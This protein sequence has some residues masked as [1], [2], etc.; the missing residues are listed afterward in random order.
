M[1]IGV[2]ISQI[3]YQTGV[4]RYTSQLI[5]NLLKFD[6]KNQYTLFAGSIRQRDLIESFYQ[7]VKTSQTKLKL[8]WLSP[9]LA[10]ILWNR[11]HL[12]PVERFTGRLDVF[13]SSDWTQ[14]PSKA[15]KVTTVHDLT[16]IKFP[17]QHHPKI[18]KTHRRRLFWVKKQADMIIADSRSTKN[19]LV[20]TLGFKKDRIR[21]VYLA[22]SKLFKPENDQKKVDSVLK[23]Y[24]INSPFIFSLGTLQPRKNMPRLIKA[25]KKTRKKHSLLQL[26]IAGSF[27][28]GDKVKPVEGVNLLGFVPD[29]DLPAIFSAAKAFVYP[30]LYE[31]FGLPVLEAMQS[32][33]PVITSN[34]SSLPEVAGKAAVYVDPESV[35]LIGKGISE[36]VGNSDLQ[37]KMTQAGLKQSKKF[38]WKKTV[39]KTLEVYQGVCGE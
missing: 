18:V 5:K 38:S 2:D 7:E 3:V 27:G 6:S 20:S 32:G 19:D 16:P 17:Q 36:V 11:F 21:V 4:S 25:F 31:G 23:K 26:A 35:D 24:Q 10:D 33:C 14:P 12:W 29:E 9:S 8:S 28:W 1:K 22:A 13:H 39:K 34:R 37:K 30:S 15:A